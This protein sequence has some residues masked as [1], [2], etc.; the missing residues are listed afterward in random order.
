MILYI[1]SVTNSGCCPA[2]VRTDCV[3]E[4]GHVLQ[5]HQFF[6]EEGI[7]TFAAGYSI[8]RGWSS[9]AVPENFFLRYS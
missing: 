9:R 4:N 6:R 5:F 8:L 7:D 3:T 1:E 2:I